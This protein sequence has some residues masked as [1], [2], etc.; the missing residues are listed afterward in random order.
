MMDCKRALCDPDVAGDLSKA[1]DWLR[2]RGVARAGLAGSIVTT[3]GLIA[4]HIEPDSTITLLEVASETD[5]VA[6]NPFFQKFAVDAVVATALSNKMLCASQKKDDLSLQLD[7]ARI[8]TLPLRHGDTPSVQDALGDL[9]G[10]VREAVSLRRAFRVPGPEPLFQESPSLLA[11]YVHGKVT[12]PDHEQSHPTT[13][14][15]VASL[16]TS[17]TQSL[18]HSFPYFKYSLDAPSPW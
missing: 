9:T 1:I 14:T 6:R 13:Q 18:T 16:L 2:K 17:L 3:E 4:V 11:A 7:V 12:L 10:R 15:Q 8:L 5:F